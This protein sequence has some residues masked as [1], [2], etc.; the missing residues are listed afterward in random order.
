MNEDF[1][2]VVNS[3]IELTESLLTL[4]ENADKDDY[5]IVKELGLL[6]IMVSNAYSNRSDYYSS[7][8][9][10]NI[11]RRIEIIKEKIE[12]SKSK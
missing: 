5:K 6:E 12:K 1:I 2:S 9:A 8:E 3:I 11:R 7:K 10:E 4:K